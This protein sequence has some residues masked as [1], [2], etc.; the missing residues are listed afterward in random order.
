[1][2]SHRLLMMVIVGLLCLSVA[3]SESYDK[4]VVRK[5]VIGTV[6]HPPPPPQQKLC[7]PTCLRCPF[8]APPPNVSNLLDMYW[9]SSPGDRPPSCCVLVDSR[10]GFRRFG[11]YCLNSQPFCW[12]QIPGAHTDP[13][14]R[15][16]RIHIRCHCQQRGGLCLSLAQPHGMPRH[17]VWHH[18]PR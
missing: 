11:S 12:G 7:A 4:V 3:Y 17:G 14:V 6:L 10:S 13:E 1:M 16:N 2:I 9:A 18:T 8:P 5:Y 15:E